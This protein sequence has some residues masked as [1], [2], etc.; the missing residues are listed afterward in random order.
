MQAGRA[1]P[2]KFSLGGDFGLGVLAGSLTSV[3]VTC[4]TQVQLNEAETASTARNSTFTYDPVTGLYQYVWKTDSTWARTCRKLTL[5]LEDG[6]AQT[7][8][9]RFRS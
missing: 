5:T 6:S 7:A 2:L 1:V 4:D 9:F 3:K 8:L